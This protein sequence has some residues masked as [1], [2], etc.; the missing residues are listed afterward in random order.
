MICQYNWAKTLYPFLER[1]GWVA[2][3]DRFLTAVSAPLEPWIHW[4]M[5]PVS[6]P[7]NSYEIFFI[8]MTLGIVGYIAGS[9]L[10]YRPFDLDK[11]L[12]RGAYSDGESTLQQKSFSWN[13]LA[14]LRKLTGIDSEYTRGD[15][16]IAWSVFI[17]SFGYVF[18]AKFLMVVVWNGISPWSKEWWS[19]Y[20]LIT[21]LI[22]PCI[23]GVISTVWFVSG[24]IHDM[25]ALF[26]ALKNRKEEADDNGQIIND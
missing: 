25:F 26:K 15:R 2:P 10:T 12:H 7:V 14:L 8:A 6:F 1:H 11:L 17:F 4:R 21:V 22:I 24:G 5:N 3:L 9:Y 20:F 16:I 23:I 18:T 13:P 19:V